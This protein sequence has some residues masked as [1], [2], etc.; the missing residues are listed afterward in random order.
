MSSEAYEEEQFP[1]NEWVRAYVP[2]RAQS[3]MIT[4]TYYMLLPT[5]AMMRTETSVV[6]ILPGEST[7]PR[8]AK[9]ISVSEALCFIPGNFT[10]K[11]KRGS[12]YVV[13]VP[14]K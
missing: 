1:R 7:V 4:I 12:Q 13:L 8:K 11:T 10:L 9:S 14:K 5:G 2:T 3:G 6:E